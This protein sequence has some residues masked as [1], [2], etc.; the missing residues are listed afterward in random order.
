MLPD[1]A[2]LDPLREPSVVAGQRDR[3]GLDRVRAA[4]G[5]LIIDE[6]SIE[7]AGEP[8]GRSSWRLVMD[9]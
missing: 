6:V 7:L 2:T 1:V 3:A 8:K 4:N 5:T 9:T